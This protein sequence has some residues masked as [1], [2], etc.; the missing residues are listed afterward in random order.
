[1][2]IN[3]KAEAKKRAIERSKNFT[4]KNPGTAELRKF[5]ASFEKLPADLRKGMRP[6]LK[7]TGD[8]ALAQARSN[9][10]W[11]SRIPRS[12]RT[13][14]SLT[15][16]SAGVS[17]TANLKVAPHARALENLG[18]PGM[19]RHPVNRDGTK[20]ASQPARPYFFKT[21]D[22]AMLKD[23]DQKIGGVVDETSRAHG[24]K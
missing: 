15:K 8:H 7:S 1:M 22:S 24:F 20:F 5:I 16:R 14:V 19:I 12:L 13:T 21:Q 10:S 6:M 3:Y 9:A 17:L 2:A 23:I 11:S 4:K 18:K